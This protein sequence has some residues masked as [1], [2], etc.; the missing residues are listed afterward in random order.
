MSSTYEPSGEELRQAPRASVQLR[1]QIQLDAFSEPRRGLTANV[2]MEGMFM[3]TSHPEPIGTLIKFKM[4]LGSEPVVSGVGEVVWIRVRGQ[5]PSSPAGMG[6]RFGSLSEEARGSLRQRLR[7][8][9]SPKLPPVSTTNVLSERPP[10]RSP[11]P[12]P[13]AERKTS[14]RRKQQQMPGRRPR[15][16]PTQAHKKALQGQQSEEG[17]PR[18]VMLVVLLAVAALIYY[19]FR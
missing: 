16:T 12:A 18:V 6:I 3:K 2:S 4:D 13:T 5:G 7:E 15:S 10:Q 9:F 1:V 11:E 8:E 19:L 14:K 17:G